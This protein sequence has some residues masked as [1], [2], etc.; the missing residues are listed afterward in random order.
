ML[1]PSTLQYFSESV[2]E[3]DGGGVEQVGRKVN[4]GGGKIIMLVSLVNTTVGTMYIL[5]SRVFA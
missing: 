3:A 2:N 1:P 4:G 5:V